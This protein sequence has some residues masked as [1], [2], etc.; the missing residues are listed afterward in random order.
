MAPLTMTSTVSLSWYSAVWSWL[1]IVF[2]ISEPDKRATPRK[3]SRVTEES[4]TVTPTV[5]VPPV[6]A[7]AG[8][9]RDV[10]W[11]KYPVLVTVALPAS[12]MVRFS[13]TVWPYWFLP[14]RT[15]VVAFQSAWLD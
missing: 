5:K 13:E 2:G 14:V 1:G 6:L 10:I 9:T 11:E 8:I 4:R 12:G 15:A 3:S 7:W